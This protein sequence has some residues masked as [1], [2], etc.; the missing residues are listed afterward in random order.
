MN[1]HHISF[2]PEHE[3]YIIDILN[4]YEFEIT[5]NESNIIHFKT[6]IPCILP[7]VEFT[8]IQLDNTLEQYIN[9]LVNDYI[10]FSK[11]QGFNLE[12]NIKHQLFTFSS[13]HVYY[14][15]GIFTSCVKPECDIRQYYRMLLFVFNT[16]NLLT[17]RLK[18]IKYLYEIDKNVSLDTENPQYLFPNRNNKYRIIIHIVFDN[19]YIQNNCDTLI[20]YGHQFLPKF[21]KDN[22]EDT[23][24]YDET[25]GDEVKIEVCEYDDLGDEIF[26]ANGESLF[27]KYVEID[28]LENWLS[29]V[30]NK[31]E[32]VKYENI[33]YN[34][35]KFNIGENC[36]SF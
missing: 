28:E 21:I 4:D 25:M 13:P 18:I 8:P 19:D 22:I 20:K 11:I 16:T 6:P 36:P 5:K 14:T 27:N 24:F 10:N 2:V 3:K 29:F 9:L 26:N 17:Y 12:I 34:D 32:A 31:Y 35:L 30:Y 7:F 1:N 15:D 23:E 33:E